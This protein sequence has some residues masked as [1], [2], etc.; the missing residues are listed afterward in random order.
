MS[1][2]TCVKPSLV[3]IATGP[4]CLKFLLFV[5]VIKRSMENNIIHVLLSDIVRVWTFRRIHEYSI[6]KKSAG[7]LISSCI[8]TNSV[9]NNTETDVHVIKHLLASAE[10]VDEEQFERAIM[11]L[12]QC[13]EYACAQGNPIQTLVYY[14]T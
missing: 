8:R 14:F 9:M 1:L 2:N 12:N 11:L 4:T 5:S 13:D 7:M 6:V 3:A 10:K